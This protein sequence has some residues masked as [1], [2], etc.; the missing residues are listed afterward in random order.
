M[1]VTTGIHDTCKFSS[2]NLFCIG[3]ISLGICCVLGLHWFL[4]YSLNSESSSS[5]KGDHLHHQSTLLDYHHHH[6]GGILS[7]QF[8]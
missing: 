2:G 8:G 3:N 6:Q 4:V 1:K 5:L 7:S